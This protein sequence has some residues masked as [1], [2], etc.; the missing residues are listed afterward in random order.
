MDWIKTSVTNA[1]FCIT[2]ILSPPAFCQAEEIVMVSRD[3]S[4]SPGNH[5]SRVPTISADGR[6][7]T[8]YSAASNLVPD[9][10]NDHADIF[11]HDRDTG[12]T[13]R[14]SMGWNGEEANQS[15][16][17]PVISADGRFI[18]FYSAASNL[19]PDDTNGVED[20]FLY[21]RVSGLVQRISMGRNGEEPDR[22]SFGPRLNADGSM[23]TF[24][25]YATNLITDDSND[26]ADIFLHDRTTGQ[27]RC[28]SRD[29]AGN[30]A[31]GHS[32]WPAISPDG[33]FVS[34]YSQASNLVAGDTN[35]RR[36]IFVFDLMAETTQRISM[37]INGQETDGDS[38]HPAVSNDG[39]FI[40]FES[41]SSNLVAGDTNGRRDIFVHDRFSGTTELISIALNG[42]PADGGS[43]WPGISSD[44]RFVV[45]ESEAGNLTVN[46]TNLTR[47]IFLHD[48]LTGKTERMSSGPG[49]EANDASFYPAISHNG[50]F[51]TFF[52]YASNLVSDD[53]NDLQDIFVREQ[54][55]CSLTFSLASGSWQLIS[56]PCSLPAEANTVAT[57]FGDDIGGAYGQDWIMYRYDAA[58]NIYIN[59]GAQGVLETGKGYWILQMTGHQVSLGLP[60]GSSPVQ[61]SSGSGCPS[62]KGCFELPVETKPDTV[63]WNLIGYPETVAQPFADTRIRTIAGDCADG[64]D[65]DTAS[66]SHIFH[67]ELWQYDGGT[68]EAVDPEEYLDVWRGYWGA[69]LQAADGLAPTLLLPR[70]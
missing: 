39:R 41:E 16:Y 8:F 13:Q 40:A 19:V 10:T 52:S 4:G 28:I 6:F 46:D 57:C 59:I 20:I 23:I 58:R 7:I 45:F 50:K 9:D 27:T 51:I 48:R 65:P 64:C 3:S 12:A 54:N 24:Y 69:T 34:Y 1:L 62:A 31:N 14:I 29:S 66:D 53:I 63:Q 2:I 15:S 37:G 60:P 56:L 32:Y 30:Q 17:A 26:R 43:F 47:D 42:Q 5:Y 22:G 55:F 36:D 33:L 61:V 67:R 68:Y 25:S 35:G 70:P 49:G 18:T 44:G 38:F 11:L 21:D